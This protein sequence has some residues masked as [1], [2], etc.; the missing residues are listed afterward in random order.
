VGA[1]LLDKEHPFHGKLDLI[2]FLKRIWPLD[3]MPSHDS[4]SKNASGDI[5][6]H[7]VHNYDWD[8]SELLHHR[9]EINEVPD[10]QLCAFLKPA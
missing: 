8:E 7:I 6:Q 9:M 4:R 10:E 2:F 5:L 1:L 3:S